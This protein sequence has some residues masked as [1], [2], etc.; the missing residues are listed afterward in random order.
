MLTHNL[1]DEF[2]DECIFV[3]DEGVDKM[4]ACMRA[5]GCV[6]DL[7]NDIS[8]MAIAARTP[9]LAVD[10]RMRCNSCKT[11]EIEGLCADSLPK[12]HIYTFATI[13]DSNDKTIEDRS[14]FDVVLARLESFLPNLNRDS[15]P[16]TSESFEVI[17]YK[18]IRSKKTKRIGTRFIKIPKDL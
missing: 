18:T 12:Q 2:T 7:F 11:K 8:M 13:I 10:E 3:K 15:W 14:L 16:S 6:V 4:M 5:V 9:Y 1:S 17:P